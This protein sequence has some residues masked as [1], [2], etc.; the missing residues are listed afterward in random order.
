[1]IS[2]N[3]W[4]KK[5]SKPPTRFAMFPFSGWISN[6]SPVGSP[7]DGWI[8]INGFFKHDKTPTYHSEFL[9]NSQF[10]PSC[11]AGL[12]LQLPIIHHH[13]PSSTAPAGSVRAS[14]PSRCVPRVRPGRVVA[15]GVGEWVGVRE[16][17]RNGTSHTVSQFGI[18]KLVRLS[19]QFHY[20][21]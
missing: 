18:A 16:L 13:P 9:L 1:M 10:F 5:C 12:L 4:K 14:R 6:S 2:P 17:D 3:I 8:R 20:G 11:A 7:L 19:L 15:P 21:L